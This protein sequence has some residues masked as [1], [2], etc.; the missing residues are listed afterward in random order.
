MQRNIALDITKGI[1]ILLVIIGHCGSIPYMPIRHLIFS[2]HM[3][4]FFLAS[5]YLHRGKSTKE[6]LKKD[7]RHLALPYIITCLVIIF[8]YFIY[9]L[10]TKSHNSEPLR[11]YLIASLWGSGTIHSCKYL[12]H[13][14]AIGAIW[15]LPALL[16]CKNVYNILPKNNSRLVYSSAIFVVATII[17]RYLIYIPF[18][19]LSGLSGIVFYAIGDCLKRVK[20]IHPLFWIIGI[21]CWFLSLKYSHVSLVQPRLDLYF[22]DVIGATTAT[23]LVYLASR[24]ISQTGLLMHSLSWAG[25]NSMYILC[26]HLIDLD[27]CISTR[28]NILGSNTMGIILSLFLPLIGSFFLTKVLTISHCK[29]EQTNI[30]KSR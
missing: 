2:F 6:A 18:S 19:A 25:K 12:S 9:Y 5:G 16:I 21:S 26:F 29:H 28:L 22:I 7:F 8:Y 17:G 14:P 30:L 20:T 27:C 1:G 24:A 23:V 10:I 11:K 13:H 4:L 15:F 3:P